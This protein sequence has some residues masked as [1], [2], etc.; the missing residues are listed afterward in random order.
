MILGKKGIMEKFLGAF[1]ALGM[2][3]L[4]GIVLMFVLN[5]SI[6]ENKNRFLA[7]AKLL[8]SQTFTN[9]LVRLP[10]NNTNNNTVADLLVEYMNE[11][12]CESFKEKLSDFVHE[13]VGISRRN[14]LVFRIK[15]VEDEDFDCTK[16]APIQYRFLDF[17][18]PQLTPNMMGEDY[19]FIATLIKPSDDVRSISEYFVPRPSRGGR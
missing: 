11:D 15:K 19:Y 8:E 17:G 2:L 5:S 18:Q 3:I 12:K 1:M 14:E 6:Q 16:G 10:V 13:E 9:S 7:E 4:I